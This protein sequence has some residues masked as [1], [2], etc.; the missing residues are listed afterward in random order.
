VNAELNE[1][2]DEIASAGCS[3][4]GRSLPRPG[5][6]CQ[7]GAFPDVT[8]EEAARELQ[9][10]GELS[11]RRASRADGD[12]LGLLYQFVAATAA[13]ERLRKLAELEIEAAEVAEALS[14]AFADRKKAAAALAEAGDAEAEALAPL[15]RCRELGLEAVAELEEVQRTL[16]GEEA[17][18]HARV[19]IAELRPM[20]TDRQR[21]YEEA[22]AVTASR[23]LDLD[24]AELQIALAERARDEEATAR[25][26]LDEVRPSAERLVMLARPLTEYM[27]ELLD[28]QATGQPQY[29]GEWANLLGLLHRMAGATGLLAIAEEGAAPRVLEDLAGPMSRMQDVAELQRRLSGSPL[30]LPAVPG[31]ARMTYLGEQAP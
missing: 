27:A 19:K 16:K 12:A 7:C 25:L 8:R 4:C 11:L 1:A 14:D 23:K 5:V 13:P 6:R 18:W 29:P 15:E 21:A 28:D 22:A 30:G 10:P 26:H 2:I 17:E 24:R 3:Q 9:K 20:L 31:E